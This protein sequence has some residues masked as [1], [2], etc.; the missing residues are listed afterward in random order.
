MTTNICLKCGKAVYG[1]YTGNNTGLYVCGDC[2]DCNQPNTEVVVSV[3][4]GVADV[5]YKPKGIAVKLIDYDDPD[6]ED[7]ARPLIYDAEEAIDERQI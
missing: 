5:V 1:A 3:Y 4:R 6:C 2:G 7:G